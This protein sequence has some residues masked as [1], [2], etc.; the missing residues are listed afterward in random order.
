MENKK[1]IL[2]IC[3][4]LWIGWTEKTMQIF[5][6]YLD[7]SKYNVFACWIFNWWVREWLIKKY[8]NNILIANWSIQE[9]KNFVIKNNINI[10]HWHSITYN[11]WFEFD[12]S[13]ELLKF[14]KSRN[15]KII[16]TSPFSLYN[17]DIDSLLDLKIFVSKTSLIKFFYKFQNEKITKNKYWYLYNPLDIEEL[18]K[19]RLNKNQ[20][21]KLRINYWIDK[22]DFI[23]WKVW[24]ANLWKWDD[25]IINIL[26]D[27]I[28]NIP[29]L[30]VIIRSIPEIKKKKINRMWLEKY[31]IF[32]PES[33]IE[34]DIT[35]TYQL[36]DLMLHTSRI[37]ESFWI[38]LV[39]WMFFW[40]PIFT[41][42]T[43][44]LNYT[45]F[46]RD[47]SQI[48]ILNNWKNWYI[49]NN[50]I[51]LIKEIINIYQN[52]KLFISISSN[53]INYVNN[54]FDAKKITNKLEKIFE[55]DYFEYNLE[56]L[57][58]YK[59]IPKENI[60]SILLENIK[61]ITDKFIFKA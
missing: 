22:N 51:L 3:N 7:K 35:E 15:I 27:L 43:N 34:K 58:F 10:V 60:T 52:R 38:T 56:D 11:L 8:V 28:K 29:N 50:N 26:P 36:M 47:N 23:I 39:E 4:Q 46:D 33:V 17:K 59:N 25:T 55:L 9:I 18:E 37:W 24:R 42:S 61:A 12:I 32:L 54:L 1:N 44:F 21:I 40:L 53:N 41:K 57:N 14:F 31:F 13:I 16:E 49:I 6:K 48:E 45:V 20:K 5:C 2:E 19:F 30:K